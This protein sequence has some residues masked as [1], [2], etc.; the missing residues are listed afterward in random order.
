M[1]YVVILLIVLVVLILYIIEHRERIAIFE[2]QK[3]KGVLIAKNIAQLNLQAFIQWDEEGIEKN[4]EE[5]IDQKLIYVVFY[6]RFNNPFVASRFIKDYEEIYQYSRLG[7]M[8]T[9]R[10]TS[11]KRKSWWT[12]TQE[13]L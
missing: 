10:V 8:L 11:L 2:G 4:I 12:E 1:V 9:R 13:K 7:R 5:Q 3:S 6:G